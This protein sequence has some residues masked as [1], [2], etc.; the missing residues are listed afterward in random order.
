MEQETEPQSLQVKDVFQFYVDYAKPLYCEIEAAGNTL[1]SELLFEIH[2]AFDHLRRIYTNGENE[3]VQAEKA[4]SHLKRSVLD[5]YKLKLKY[6]NDDLKKLDKIDLTFIDNGKYYKGFQ[7]QR[8]EIKQLGKQARLAEG[9][10]GQ[11]AFT[12]WDE[13]SKK[14]DQFFDDYLADTDNISWAK[15][16]T[17]VIFC[18]NTL[19]SFT[20]GV[21]SGIIASYIF[22]FLTA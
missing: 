2:A 20:V 8:E 6:F 17:I 11:E 9:Q 14:I 1:P 10:D 4:C 13:V 22:L 5:A 15:R 7:K 16:K 18:K 19:I 21:L 12:L 3:A